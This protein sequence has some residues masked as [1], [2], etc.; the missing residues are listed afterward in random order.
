MLGCNAISC[1]HSPASAEEVSLHSESIL[2]K[3][4]DSGFIIQESPIW[5]SFRAQKCYSGSHIAQTIES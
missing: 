3:M 5:A 4:V 1:C 2:A